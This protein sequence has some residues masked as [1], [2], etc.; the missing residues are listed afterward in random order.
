M[1]KTS[2]VL[3]ELIQVNMTK[4]SLV[5]GELISMCMWALEAP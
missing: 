1:T 4:T 5:L 2:L 3:G